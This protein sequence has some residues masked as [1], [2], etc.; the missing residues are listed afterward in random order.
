[1]R[2]V[3]NTTS[4]FNSSAAPTEPAVVIIPPSYRPKINVADL[5]KTD[6]PPIAQN[7]SLKHDDKFY[8]DEAEGGFCIFRAEN[9]LFKVCF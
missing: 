1:M 5:I 9:T 8:R 4:Q 7:S 6:F 2:E 3:N